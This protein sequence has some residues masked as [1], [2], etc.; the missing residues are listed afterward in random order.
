VNSRLANIKPH[1]EHC[2][3]AFLALL[4]FVGVVVVVDTDAAAAG[5]LL[6]DGFVS[7]LI[8]FD[9]DEAPCL[10]STDMACARC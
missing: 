9:F 1:D 4:D 3:V 6:F 2:T 10:V 5:T 7:C 8:F